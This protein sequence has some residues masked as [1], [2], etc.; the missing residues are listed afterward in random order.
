[1]VETKQFEC[2]EKLSE[3]IDSMLYE[4]GVEIAAGT[5]ECNGAEYEISLRVQG[6]VDVIY[7]GAKYKSPY[8]FPEELVQLI[9]ERH[10]YDNPDVTINES[11]WFEYIVTVDGYTDGFV[12]EGDMTEYTPEDIEADMREIVEDDNKGMENE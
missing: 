2:Y 11:N 6:S 7:K 10:F 1:M 5:F 9:K 12:F 4:S 3:C 8:K